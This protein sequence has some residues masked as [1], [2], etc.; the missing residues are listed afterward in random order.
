M[1]YPRRQRLMRRILLLKGMKSATLS[2][3]I[4]SIL[5]IFDSQKLFLLFS[6]SGPKRARGDA[7]DGGRGR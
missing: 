3:T 6:I 2:L 5:M 7:T 4:M 1:S